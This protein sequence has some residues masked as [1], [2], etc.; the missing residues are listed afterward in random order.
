M[1][2]RLSRETD[3]VAT[4]PASVHITQA[5]RGSNCLKS[6]LCCT[7]SEHVKSPISPFQMTL[8]VS[9]D[10]LHYS[11]NVDVERRWHTDDAV[12]TWPTQSSQLQDES[13]QGKDT[14]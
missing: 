14:H 9:F 3:I 4:R 6:D 8:L 13:A 12:L 11:P 1:A 5:M 10:A 7:L 2:D